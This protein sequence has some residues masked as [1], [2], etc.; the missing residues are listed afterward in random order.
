GLLR[1]ESGRRASVEGL[2]NRDIDITIKYLGGS[3]KAALRLVTEWGYGDVDV[4]EKIDRANVGRTTGPT[5]RDE[6]VR[7]MK[8]EPHP[9]SDLILDLIAEYL[10]RSSGNVADEIRLV[11]ENNQIKI[12]RAD[13]YDK[14]PD[15]KALFALIDAIEKNTVVSEKT[16]IRTIGLG[17]TTI[18]DLMRDARTAPSMLYPDL[19][20]PTYKQMLRPLLEALEDWGKTTNTRGPTVVGP[21]LEFNKIK[22][23]NE[24]GQLPQEIKALLGLFIPTFR[25]IAQ[26]PDRSGL[27][28]DDF[29][30]SL[31]DDVLPDFPYF[32]ASLRALIDKSTEK[33]RELIGKM[34]ESHIPERDNNGRF[35][36]HT[37]G[38]QKGQPR[39]IND[40]LAQRHLG[41]FDRNI[42]TEEREQRKKATTVQAFGSHTNT[43]T[44]ITALYGPGFDK[45]SMEDIGINTEETFRAIFE[46]SNKNTDDN[47]LTMRRCFPTFRLFFIEEDTKEGVWKA[48]DDLYGYNS[49]ISLTVTRHKY[50]ADLAEVKVTNLEG[51]LESDK[52]GTSTARGGGGD[53]RYRK[54]THSHQQ[55]SGDAG[56]LESQTSAT[57]GPREPGTGEAP[58]RRFPLSEGTRIKIEMGYQSNPRFLE[59]VF[60]G[61]IAEVT[62]GDIVTFVAQ[63]YLQELLFPMVNNPNTEKTRGVIETVMNSETVQHFGTW[64]PFSHQTL[65]QQEK[66]NGQVHSGLPGFLSSIGD[67]VANFYADPKLRN[68]WVAQYGTYW[69]EVLSRMF[70][71]DKWETAGGTKTGWDVIQDIVSYTPGYVAAVVPYDSEAT[72]F[73]GRPEQPYFWTDSMQ[74]VHKDWT[75]THVR[76]KQAT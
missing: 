52:F 60:T 50:Q 20:L 65:S 7:R 9:P 34:R 59:T 58:L 38:K 22:D 28:L 3:R 19:H 15:I 70:F 42:P 48:I 33:S 49:V 24:L 39:T 44:L 17:A 61:K 35:L 32:G 40:P 12:V 14:T 27:T 62:M 71:Q 64:T 21:N 36:V 6:D 51:N 1:S 31:D 67:S 41:P 4:L 37:E 2:T 74:D 73:V 53:P 46:A 30:Y 69:S 76:R 75:A 29:A 26:I 43:E 16:D 55:Q 56:S 8:L 10:F 68:V 18:K 13:G 5:G 45:T 66:N 54:R 23:A 72:L 63:G 25:Q 57:A 11:E 47:L